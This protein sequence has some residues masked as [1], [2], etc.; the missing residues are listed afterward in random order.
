LDVAVVR[1]GEVELAVAGVD[2]DVVERGE[3]AAIVVVYED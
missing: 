1:V 3:L 2:G